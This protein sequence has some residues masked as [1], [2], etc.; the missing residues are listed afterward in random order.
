M[1]YII[2]FIYCMYKYVIYRDIIDIFSI[3]KHISNYM[4]I[5][6]YMHNIHIL[7]RCVYYIIYQT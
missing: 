6:T 7:H 1:S 4:Y 5:Y 2:N 3:Y